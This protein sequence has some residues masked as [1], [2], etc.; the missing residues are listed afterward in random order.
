MDFPIQITINSAHLDFLQ[1]NRIFTSRSGKAA[2][3]WLKPGA[4]LVMTGPVTVEPYCEFQTGPAFHS[5]G[6]FSYSRSSL[7][8]GGGL[9]AIR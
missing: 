9:A 3:S 4:T 5:L 2:K 8:G 1:E 7:G 6:A